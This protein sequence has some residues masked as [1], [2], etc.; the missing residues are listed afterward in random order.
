MITRILNAISGD[1]PY[2]LTACFIVGYTIAVLIVTLIVM[3]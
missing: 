1:I 2:S 3:I